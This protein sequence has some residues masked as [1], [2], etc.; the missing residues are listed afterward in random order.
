MEEEEEVVE[1]GW[2]P[3]WKESFRVESCAGNFGIFETPLSA[4]LNTH[5]RE[6]F[7]FE[8]R[9]DSVPLANITGDGDSNDVVATWIAAQISDDYERRG[10]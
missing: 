5:E 8:N 2:Q 10:E 9:S 1:G 7:I 3:G 6:F 4:K